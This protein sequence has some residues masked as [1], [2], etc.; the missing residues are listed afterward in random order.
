MRRLVCHSYGTRAG[1]RVESSPEP[2]PEPG[3]VLVEITAANVA[4]VDRLIV[5]GGYQVRPPLPFTPGVVGAGTIRAVGA[6]VDGLAPGERVVVLTLTSGVWATHVAVA[7]GAVAPIPDGV[8]DVIAAAAIEAYGTAGYALEDRGG[9]AAG[10]RVLVLGAGGAVGHAAVEIAVHLG[11][12]VIGLT[13]DPEMWEQAPV[14]PHVILDR[15]VV[16]LREAMK[17]RFP[18][19]VDVVLDPVGGDSAELALRSLGPRG[20][21]LVVGFASGEIPSI[22]LNQVLLRNRSVVGV[23]WATWIAAFPEMLSTSLSRV[24]ERLASGALHPPDPMTVSLD[25]LPDVLVAPAPK[26]GLIRTVLLP[27]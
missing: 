5:R 21:Y 9:L 7:A 18:D 12:E 4:F 15:R 3:Q 25:D 8:P 22:P 27:T 2:E 1:M 24:L 17:E 10:E 19:G 23:E 16:H 13:S 26:A 20:R 14:R 6:G 11:A